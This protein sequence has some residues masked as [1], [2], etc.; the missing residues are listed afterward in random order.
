MVCILPISK[1]EAMYLRK[2]GYSAYVTSTFS[3]WKHYNV[4]EEPKILKLLKE[5]RKSKT[6]YS[7][8]LSKNKERG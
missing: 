4:V 8:G 7:Y 5:Y 3:R 2:E 1:D 6:S